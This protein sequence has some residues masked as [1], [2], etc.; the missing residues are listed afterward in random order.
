MN[1]NIIRAGKVIQNQTSF[2]FLNNR[3]YSHK[4]RYASP[5]FRGVAGT[6]QTI[7]KTISLFPAKNN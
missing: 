3:T 5:K 1:K 7:V 6:G 4:N 2:D